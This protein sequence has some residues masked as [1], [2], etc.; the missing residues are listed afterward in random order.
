MPKPTLSV[1][2]NWKVIGFLSF[3]HCLMLRGEYTCII[4]S[5]LANQHVPKALLLVWYVLRIII[6]IRCIVSFHFIGR[7]LTTWPANNCLQISVLLQI[8]FCSCVIEMLLCENGGSVP[9]AGRE[10]FAIVDQKNGDRMI[11]Q[12]LNS[13][14]AKYCD[15]SGSRRSIIIIVCLSCWLWQIIDLLAT[16]K[17]RYFAQRCSIII[18]IK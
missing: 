11:K 8:I 4:T 14:I 10:W 7:E 17:S 16:D 18:C 9:R 12:L 2:M 15:L 6:I 13:V 5:N 3:R 1:T